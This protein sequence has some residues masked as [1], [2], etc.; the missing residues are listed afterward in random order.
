MTIG[1]LAAAT[2]TRV[3]TV[4]WYEKMKLLPAPE[5]SAGNYRLYGPEHL[6][7]L[8]FIR[9]GRDLGFTVD[10]I[11]ELLAMADDRDRSCA[12]VDTIARAHLAQ[13][14]RK[15]ADLTRLAHE[16]RDVI[17]QCGCGSVADCRIIE[18][19]SP[20]GDPS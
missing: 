12:E 6:R 15:L 16:L 8:S 3:E 17:G 1:D 2:N 11:R 18:A 10:Q 4:R 7:R 5:R 9:R 13:V 14:E 19:L 20:H